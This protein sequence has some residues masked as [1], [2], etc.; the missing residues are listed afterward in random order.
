MFHPVIKILNAFNPQ[1]QWMKVLVQGVKK[2]RGVQ[3]G[4]GA[5]YKFMI[6]FSV[7]CLLVPTGLATFIKFT[8][9]LGQQKSQS[10]KYFR[11]TFL[12]YDLSD[13]PR[14]IPMHHFS[15]F[16]TQEIKDRIRCKIFND[17]VQCLNIERKR[18]L[19][20]GILTEDFELCMIDLDQL[21]GLNTT[22]FCVDHYENNPDIWTEAYS[23]DFVFYWQRLHNCYQNTGIEPGR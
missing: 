7:G 22:E 6:M 20:K 16:D 2:K 21:Q 5:K 1:K 19:A 15:F 18:C 14:L 3:A 4:F 13:V 17:E 10:L 11:E 23:P 9:N 8:N 12:E